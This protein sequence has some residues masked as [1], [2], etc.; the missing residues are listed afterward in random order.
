MR[1]LVLE[2][3]PDR[4]RAFNQNLIGHVVEIVTHARPC[5]EKLQNEK[6]DFLFL[7]HDLNGQVYVPS[8]PDTGWEVAQWLRDNP[9]KK[10]YKIQIQSMNSDGAIKMLELLPEAMWRPG[11]CEIQ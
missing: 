8:G 4:M 3:N 11:M 7:D 10:P 9:E 5:M 1:I 2:D 6:W